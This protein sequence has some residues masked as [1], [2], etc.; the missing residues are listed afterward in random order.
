MA[1]ELFDPQLVI[2]RLKDQVS[3][4]KEV[5]GAVDFA[6]A[7]ES[8]VKQ[9]PA[10]F[11]VELAD[12]PARNSLATSA[13]SQSNESRFGVIFAVQNLRDARG[14]QARADLRTLRLAVLTALLN[15][16]PDPDFDPC[17]YGGGRLL[18]FAN[19]VLWWQDD[20]ITGALL[21]SI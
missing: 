16:Q 17:E 10:A 2:A 11:V 6:A 12:R 5:G 3:A 21:R 19:L 14:E 1:I 4:L 9:T 18:Q 8:G 7:I 15:W 20:F 13:M